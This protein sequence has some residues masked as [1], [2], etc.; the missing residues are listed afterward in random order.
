MIGACALCRRVENVRKSHLLPAALYKMIR[1]HGVKN[2]NPRLLNQEGSHT[3]SKQISDYMLCASCEHRF[4]VIGEDWVLANCCRSHTDFPLHDVL[5]R[6]TPV[7]AD[8]RIRAYAA[9]HIQ[10]VDIASLIYFGVSVFWR[11]SAHRWPQNSNQPFITLGSK[12]E[13]QFRCYLLGTG[14]FPDHAALPINV[15]E[16]KTP[17]MAISTPLGGKHPGYHQYRFTIPGIVFH[18]NVG[19]LIPGDR[20]RL[21]AVRS[22]GNIIYVTGITE[23][24]IMGDMKLVYDTARAAGKRFVP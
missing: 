6:A 10:G 17:P 12:Y 3:T 21:C 20:R 1:Q 23:K 7:L 4:K 18:L 5:T 11:A 8:R 15:T 14:P 24:G 19:K 13:E 9:A 2:P 16:S 22:P